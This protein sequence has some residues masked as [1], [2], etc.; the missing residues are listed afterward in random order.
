MKANII[1][2]AYNEANI[3]AQSINTL[4][5]MYP[6]CVISVATDGSKDATT[7]IALEQEL[8]NPNVFV[9]YYPVRIGKGAAIKEAI[10]LGETNIFIDTDLS[11]DPKTIEQMITTA[12]QIDGLVI[13]KRQNN[14]RTFKRRILTSLY[15]NIA[16]LLF[17]TGVHDHQAGL[18]A[19]SPKASAVATTVK[20]TDFFFD[21]ELIVRC[22]QYNIPIVEQ[23]VIWTEHKKNST[24]NIFHDSMRMFKQLIKLRLE[25][26]KETFIKQSFMMDK[27]DFMFLAFMLAIVLIGVLTQG[28]FSAVSPSVFMLMIVYAYFDYPQFRACNFLRKFIKNK[29]P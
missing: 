25:L 6:D 15:N 24:V 19:M 23:Q 28:V 8:I 13:A 21:T 22:K 4:T 12:Q 9:N 2:P 27:A 11:A 7:E 29:K 17:S 26:V 14:N 3:I 16:K 20:S 10:I 5:K 1:I 18:K